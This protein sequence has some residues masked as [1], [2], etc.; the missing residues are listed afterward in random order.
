MK[1]S[2]AILL[3]SLGAASAFQSK[4]AFGSNS[5]QCHFDTSQ[6]QKLS[7][8]LQTQQSPSKLRMGN[9]F[10]DSI[11]PGLV[12]IG[13]LAYNIFE[14]DGRVKDLNKWTSTVG[15]KLNEVSTTTLKKIGEA[16]QKAAQSVEETK[17]K[18]TA[19]EVKPEPVRVPEPVAVSVS[20][21]PVVSAPVAKPVPAPAPEKPVLTAKNVASTVEEQRQ[22]LER[23]EKKRAAASE[24][25]KTEDKPEEKAVADESNKKVKGRKRK[26]ALRV[27]KKVV[28]PWRKWES[29]A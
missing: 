20:A 14:D 2:T 23:V 4:P 22:T 15:E 7:L 17:T 25:T 27:L 1:A 13:C 18:T 21:P 16:E 9:D 26:L 28:A 29:I 6:K 10:V 5:R 24:S 11:I 12:I 3:L 19:V 8:R